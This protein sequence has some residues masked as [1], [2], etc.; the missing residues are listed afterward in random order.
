MRTSKLEPP[1]EADL[2]HDLAAI[3]HAL[4]RI[5]DALN[6]DLAGQRPI[7]LTVMNG[8]LLTAGAL[9]PRLDVDVE[10]DFVHASRYRGELSGTALVWY[11]RPRADMNGRIVLLVDDILD[12]GYTLKELE[13]YCYENGAEQVYVV[14]LAIKDHDRR[15]EA[16]TAHYHGLMVP[17]RYVFGFGMDYRNRGRNLPGIYAV[18]E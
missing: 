10:F 18:R 12:E 15:V 2:I 7:M 11:A 8:G 16:C 9:A 14:V 17:D 4:D 3:E 1:V 13:E 6:T 5:A